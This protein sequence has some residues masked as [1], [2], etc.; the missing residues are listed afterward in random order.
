MADI[1]AMS[2]TYEPLGQT[3]L[4]ALASG[5]PIVAFKGSVITATSELL[6]PNE[7]VYTSNVSAEGLHQAITTLVNNPEKL[8]LL[9]P[10]L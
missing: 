6:S 1:F 3:I 4:E 7:A 5:L 9:G 10:K 2:S 8:Q